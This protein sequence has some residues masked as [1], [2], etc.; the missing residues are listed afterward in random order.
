LTPAVARQQKNSKAASAIDATLREKLSVATAWEQIRMEFGQDE[1]RVEIFVQNQVVNT[2]HFSDLGFQKE[3]ATIE[4]VNTESW[5]M[6]RKMALMG[7]EFP[8]KDA[9]FKTKGDLS[10]R[11]KALFQHLN[12]E[13]IKCDSEKKVYRCN[14]QLKD[15][16]GNR[17]NFIDQGRPGKRPYR[18]LL[19]SV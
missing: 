5:G 16:V 18:P 12:G 13:P 10:K 3:S 1:T 19:K 11:L 7:G 6:L 4:C 14:F 2:Y 8:Y 15:K 17:N 9:D